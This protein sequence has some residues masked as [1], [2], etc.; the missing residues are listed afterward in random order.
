MLSEYYRDNN[1]SEMDLNCA[2]AVLYVADSVYGM[3][4]TPETMKL[5]SAFGGGMAIED[6]CG[7][8]TAS[9]MV[10]GFLFV[11]KKAHESSLIKEITREFFKEFESGMGSLDCKPLKISHRTESDGCRPVISSALRILDLVISKHSAERVR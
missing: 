7:A 11:E 5:S 10:L 2:E 8:I 6:K 1:I 9:L 3:G 4:L